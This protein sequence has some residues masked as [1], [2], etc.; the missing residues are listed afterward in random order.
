MARL[1]MLIAEI[2]SVLSAATSADPPP[3][4]VP[5]PTN[6]T[7]TASAAITLTSASSIVFASE[8]L[9]SVA[10]VL[11]QELEA[12]HGLKLPTKLGSAP[13][14]RDIWLS[15]SKPH[16][17]PPPPPAPPPP[18]P[19]PPQCKLSP[20]SK[21]NNTQ[22]ADPNGPRTTPDAAGCCSLCA[23]TAGCAAWSFQLDPSVPGKM[24]HWATLTYCCW[25]HSSAGSIGPL[26]HDPSYTSGTVPAAPPMPADLPAVK[27]PGW[28]DTSY[29]L[30]STDNRI[31]VTA[32]TEAGALA[33]TTT[34]LQAVRRGSPGSATLPAMEIF[35]RPFR[36]WRG[37]QLDLHGT[38]Y[39]SIP[40]LKQYVIRCNG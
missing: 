29:T 5:W 3:P 4:L 20:S 38:P 40:L 16:S 28:P 6:F 21:L 30:T 14:P 19:K 27:T 36:D 26:V 17:S 39:H 25:M 8:S 22:W 12:V 32:S 1:G 18:P 10:A 24:C 13:A 15:L 11:A 2:V 37:L 23:A 31:V 34:L 9:A 7:S 35:D 33:G